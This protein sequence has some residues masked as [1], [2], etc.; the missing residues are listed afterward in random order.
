M[1]F[2]NTSDRLY[3]LKCSLLFNYQENARSSRNPIEILQTTE[4]K[5]KQWK[6]VVPKKVTEKK[7]ELTSLYSMIDK[8]CSDEFIS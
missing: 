5:E 1:E 2:L 7:V 4:Y 8:Y 3:F 6:Y